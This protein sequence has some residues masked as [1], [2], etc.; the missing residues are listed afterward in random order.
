MISLSHLSK[1]IVFLIFL[2]ILTFNSAIAEE[3][4]AADIWEQKNDQEENNETNSETYIIT[5]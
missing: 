4:E 1:L 2:N 5:R 3:N